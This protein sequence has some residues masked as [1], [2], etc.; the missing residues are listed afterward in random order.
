MFGRRAS[1]LSNAER[2]LA[3]RVAREKLPA[4]GGNSVEFQR[5]V[6]ADSRVQFIDPALFSLFIQIALA[7]FQYYMN[8]K[9]S[10][11][12]GADESDAQ[13]LKKVA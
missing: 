12:A 3:V 7:V 4:A 6:K 9:T 11:S 1:K 2:L 13:I 8:R 10:A 5:L